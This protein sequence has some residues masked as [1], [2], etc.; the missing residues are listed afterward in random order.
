MERKSFEEGIILA[1]VSPPVPHV[2]KK[3][4]AYSY[5]GVILP[6]LPEWN[7]EM[8]I[9]KHLLFGSPIY[10]VF[11][12]SQPYY[13][14]ATDGNYSIGYQ[15]GDKRY[16]AEE[17]EWV[18]ETTYEH[19]GL[20]AGLAEV[21]WANFDVLDESGEVALAKSEPIPVYE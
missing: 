17:S 13:A 21:I 15:T 1:L 4:I 20:W 18:Y 5:N 7:R 2:V 10:R 14:T 8:Y 11:L 12:V 16:K 3:P 19:S 6:A 9:T